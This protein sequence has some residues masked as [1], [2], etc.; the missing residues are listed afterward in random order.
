MVTTQINPTRVIKEALMISVQLF[1]LDKEKQY[2]LLV[3]YEKQLISHRELKGMTGYYK[4]L[5]KMNET[6]ATI[7]EIDK[8]INYRMPV[9]KSL[10][11]TVGEIDA[12]IVGIEETLFY[13]LIAQIDMQKK[14]IDR[15]IASISKIIKDENMMDLIPTDVTDKI[16]KVIENLKLERQTFI[17]T[18]AKL[19]L[20][21][22]KK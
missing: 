6:V 18:L 11:T 1:T 20:L 19:H 7:G 21:I 16:K 8:R 15:N 12:K 14:S 22:A 5:E 17:D 2:E 10:N 13:E 9:I 3:K 4:T